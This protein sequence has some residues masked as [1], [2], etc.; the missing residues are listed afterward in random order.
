MS[1]ITRLNNKIS[2]YTAGDHTALLSLRRN[3]ETGGPRH[4]D[5]EHWNWQFWNNPYNPDKSP[6]VWIFKDNDQIL[7]TQAS[8][9]VSLRAGDRY[10]RCAWAVDALVDQSF[11]NKGIGA[12]L[13]RKLTSSVDI[14]L[15]LGPTN[16]AYRMFK[17]GGWT[18]MGCIPMFIK[19]IS[20]RPWIKK[21]IR[22]PVVSDVISGLLSIVLKFRDFQLTREAKK[23][24][25]N[26]EQIDH[27]NEGFD[28]FWERVSGNFSI[29]SKRDRK[30]LN[31]RY[32]FQ[33]GMSYTILKAER[34]DEI[35]GYIVLRTDYDNTRY[36]TTTKIGYI[37]DFLAAPEQITPIIMAAINYFKK[38]KVATIV[39]N[40]LNKQIEEIMKK[41]GFHRRE[42]G[43]RFMIK[44]N[45]PGLHTEFL[46]NR[47]NWFITCGESGHDGDE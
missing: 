25:A 43:T 21:R 45:N 38:E 34:Q 11:R 27:F 40:I 41:F 29:I 47:D 30:Y 33:P 5:E 10:L 37:V 36:D 19:I 15:A 2:K 13:L 28:D 23:F 20:V 39:C 9:P 46:Q 42:F 14:G 17:R 6:E 35:L 18:D 12:L 26:V 22:F 16:I 8:I 31:W 4:L 3:I 24:H 1:Y 7:G 32:A 44:V